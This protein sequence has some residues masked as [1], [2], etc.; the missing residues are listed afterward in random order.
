MMKKII[1]TLV[2]ALFALSTVA[3]QERGGWGIMPKMSIYTN[4]S[5]IVGIGV[6][7]RYSITDTWRIEPGITALLHN[8]C[9]VDINCDV[10]YLFKVADKWKLYPLLGLSANDIGKWAVGMNVGG[11]VDYT[12]TRNWDISAGLKW[13][14]VFDNERPN[15]VI[16]SI[17]G[18]Y[19]F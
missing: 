17:G 3:A 12:V 1:F 5:T 16:I 19:R 11:G 13:Q 7:A 8:G 4:T 14:P 2:I 15:P 10:Q 6:A 18:I 9:S